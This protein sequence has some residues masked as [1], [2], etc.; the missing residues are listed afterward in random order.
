M[1]AEGSRLLERLSDVWRDREEK[2]I[3]RIG[4]K[5]ARDQLLA[6]LGRLRD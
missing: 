1:T 4:G 3:D 6:L 2:L 5:K